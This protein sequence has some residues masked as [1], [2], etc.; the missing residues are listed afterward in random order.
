[1]KVAHV[2]GYFQP[3]LGYREYYYAR[4]LSKKGIEVHVITSNKIY[5]FRDSKQFFKDLGLPPTRNRQIG[6]EFFDG[7]HIHRL[8]SVFELHDLIFVKGLQ[9]CI[10]RINPNI[11][12]AYEGRQGMSALPYRYADDYNYKIYYEHEQRW[13]KEGILRKLDFIL[14][15]PFIKNISMS[16]EIINVASEASKNFLTKNFKGIDN[17][18]KMLP[19]GADKEIF[20][21]VNNDKTERLRAYL[22]ISKDEKVII[23]VG[24]I[25]PRKDFHNLL[26]SFFN[27][28]IKKKLILLILG[29]GKKKY[30]QDLN[31]LSEKLRS[32]NKRVIFHGSVRNDKLK[33]YYSIADLGVWY[34]A[35]ISIIEAMAT[36]LPLLI[37][38]S[39]SVNH[40]ISNNSGKFYNS[41]NEFSLKVK[42]IFSSEKKIN[43]MR[44]H[45]QKHFT[46]YFDY[47]RITNELI[48]RYNSLINK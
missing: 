35:S 25:T 41:W 16:A 7:L 3:E 23:T 8:E 11:I 22:N 24:Q 19:L 30:I 28:D 9:S 48:N 33:Y 36:G 42:E 39:P 46:K 14:R 12:H 47:N 26:K 18:I 13:I 1:M 45:T 4:N 20:S 43:N 29:S 34:Q 38:Y 6:Y 27:I 21:Y 37:Y 15:R 2:I 40:L 44:K 32:E 17:K 10:K 31:L 5:P